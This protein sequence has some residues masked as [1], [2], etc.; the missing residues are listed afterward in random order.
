MTLSSESRYSSG[1]S[2][3]SFVEVNTGLESISISVLICFSWTSSE[4][5]T[6]A[7]SVIE[8]SI[9][10]LT[11]WLLFG[12]EWIELL[13]IDVFV[14]TWISTTDLPGLECVSKPVA[15]T[16]TLAVPSNFSSKIEPT[17]TSAS[18]CTCS[19]ISLVI[20]ST[21]WRVKSVPPVILINKPLA[22][23]RE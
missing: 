4:W 5:V 20:L 13:T 9:K 17:I 12:S 18:G 23:S 14:A 19:L 22:P 10:E 15:T 7:S 2:S 6:V 11:A 8:S 1:D 3:D 16:D 21:S